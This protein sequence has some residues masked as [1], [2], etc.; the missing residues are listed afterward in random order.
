MIKFPSQVDLS[1]SGSVGTL[2]NSTLNHQV[3]LQGLSVFK[4]QG[5][6]IDP[7]PIKHSSSMKVRLVRQFTPATISYKFWA[8]ILQK[9]KT[10]KL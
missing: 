2:V 9:K 6:I 1:A 8:L 3:M 4:K 7:R 10:F 5:Y